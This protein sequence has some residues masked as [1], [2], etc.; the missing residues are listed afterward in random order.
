MRQGAPRQASVLIKIGS[1]E[2]VL[3]CNK[4]VG[5]FELPCIASVS[6]RRLLTQP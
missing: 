5:N 3:F 4:R 6:A 1:N 2:W